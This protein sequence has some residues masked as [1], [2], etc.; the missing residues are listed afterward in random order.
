MSQ[1]RRLRDRCT[2]IFPSIT[3]AATTSIVTGRYPADHGIAGAFWY[4]PERETVAYYG[5]DFWVIL[6]RGIDDFVNDFLVRLNQDRLRAATL[7]ERVEDGDRTAASL[8]YLAHHGRH[9][10]SLRWTATWVN[11]RRHAAGRPC[12]SRMRLRD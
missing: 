6:R 5:Y 4:E 8:N 2:S 7:F 11:C 3:P 10:R 9:D 1:T 12:E